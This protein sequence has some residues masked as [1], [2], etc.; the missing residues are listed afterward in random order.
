MPRV[1]ILGGGFAGLSAAREFERLCSRQDGLECVLVDRQNYMLF[2][3]MLPEAMSG[4]VEVGDILRSFRAELHHVRFE[5]GDVLSVD[6]AAR[7]VHVRD[8]ITR[9]PRS[10]HYDEL[11]LALGAVPAT[12]GI[13]GVERC[14]FPLATAADAERLHN[15]IV[16]AVEVAAGTNDVVERDRLLRFVVVGGGFNGVETAGELSAFLKRLLRYYPSLQNARADIVL[17]Q[18]A[19]RLLPEL[20]ER[21]G[22]LAARVLYD[23]GVSVQNGTRIDRVDAAGVTTG[24]G[25][26]YESRTVVWSAGSEPAPFV[27][28]LHLKLSTHGA[29]VTRAD[30]SV[31]DRASLWAIGDCAA[32]PQADGGTYARLAQNAMREG[33]LAAKNIASSL[34]GKPTRPFRYR[35]LGQMASLGDRYALAELPGERMIAGLAA[36]ILWRGYYLGQLP[37]VRQKA[38][39]AIDWTLGAALG[40]SP[41]QAPVIEKGD[42]FFEGFDATRR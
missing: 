19:E 42:A 20:P 25:G 11:L 28:R 21:F 30:C 6:E 12:H 2:T 17:L 40:P 26:R 24:D 31:P 41:S 27:K 5:L 39:V 23:R 36:W 13:E 35:E 29:I 3:P 34:R 16:G 33:P 22:A 9:E 7:C 10:I 18:Q 1:V 4:A 14:T 32:I 8:P 15:R 38:R 37:G